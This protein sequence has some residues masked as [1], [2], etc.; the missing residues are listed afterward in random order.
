MKND[1][2]LDQKDM[3]VLIASRM[4]CGHSQSVD[5]VSGPPRTGKTKILSTVLE[6]SKVSEANILVCAP[7]ISSFSVLCS[8]M[9]DSI[10]RRP[11]RS[12][13][14]PYER[15]GDVI[16]LSDK[17]DEAETRSSQVKKF[18][19]EYRLR[20]IMPCMTWKSKIDGFISFL[21][22]GFKKKAEKLE[23]KLKEMTSGKNFMLQLL[24][25]VLETKSETLMKLL[26]TLWTYLP[27][28]L[29][30]EE[31][32]TRMAALFVSLEEL[33]SLLQNADV[34][35]EDIKDTFKLR[36]AESFPSRKLKTSLRRSN[37][38][39][40]V[41]I[42]PIVKDMRRAKD[43]CLKRL[44]YIGRHANLPY[45]RD[46][47]S[48]RKFLIQKTSIILATP[49]SS[50]ELHNIDRIPIDVL[51]VEGAS[52]IRECELLIPLTL[53]SLS[54]VILAGDSF[55]LNTV[56]VS[57]VTLLLILLPFIAL[58]WFI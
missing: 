54:H 23:D 19:I 50:F 28:S 42:N 40:Y 34:T 4:K 25:E 27:S 49:S 47:E 46:I 53:R 5:I 17:R 48:M 1:L 38:S 12:D 29:F 2:D 37:A 30:S 32:E 13:V 26:K 43:E 58:S 15:L 31:V 20:E 21:E 16:L 33:K 14:L 24:K 36:R 51:F 55:Q 56:N 7:N 39:K 57:K 52:R 3:A 41:S 22:E 35:E 9:L 11:K 6:A 45:E 10:S 44:K 8:N 18:C